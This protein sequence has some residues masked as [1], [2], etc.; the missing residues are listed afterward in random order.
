MV[1][2]NSIKIMKILAGPKVKIPRGLKSILD[3]NVF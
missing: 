2:L 1:L 3:R